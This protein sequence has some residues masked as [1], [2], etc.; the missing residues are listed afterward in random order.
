MKGEGID[1][2][3]EYMPDENALRIYVEG[4]ERTDCREKTAEERR[5]GSL[6]KIH[7]SDEF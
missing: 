1:V 6:F 4:K 2:R 7:W 3:Y 5:I